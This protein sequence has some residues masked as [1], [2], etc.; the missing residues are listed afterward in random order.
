MSTSYVA[1]AE[2]WT[3]PATPPTRMKSTPPCT[4]DGRSFSNSAL[5]CSPLFRRDRVLP[6]LLTCVPKLSRKAHKFDKFF[7]P[8][9]RRQFQ[10][11]TQQRAIN[12]THVFA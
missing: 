1:R 9:R 7:E 8:L 5:T 6:R 10:V 3:I 2:P 12:I 11:L 4:S